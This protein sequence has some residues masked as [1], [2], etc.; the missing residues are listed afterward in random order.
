MAATKKKS[1]KPRASAAKS[2]PVRRKAAPVRLSASDKQSKLKPGDD[3]NELISEINTAWGLVAR[4]VRVGD[5]SR[6]QLVSLGRKAEKV[7]ARESELAAKQAARLAPLTDAR[8][9]ANDLAYRAA[10]KVKRIADAVGEAD[11]AVADAFA[12]VNERFRRIG[13]PRPADPT[14]PS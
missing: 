6:A 3:L 14:Q 12:S 13:A 10:L 5:V 1:S 11:A 9:V 7:A 4:K 8:I 2:K